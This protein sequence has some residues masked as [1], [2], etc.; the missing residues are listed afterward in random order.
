LPLIDIALRDEDRV[1]RLTRSSSVQHAF[2]EA[3]GSLR[4]LRHLTIDL[5]DQQWEVTGNGTMAGWS[6]LQSLVN[7]QTLT[8]RHWGET[9]LSAIH[10][11]VKLLYH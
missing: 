11:L 5:S 4:L 9:H 3:I 2:L 10:V 1:V 7:L 8:L 6:H